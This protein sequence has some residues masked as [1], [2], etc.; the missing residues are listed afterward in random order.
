MP[1]AAMPPWSGSASTVSSKKP[2]STAPTRSTSP[3]SSGLDEKTAIRYAHSARAL[4]EQPLET[5]PAT[6]PRTPGSTP[7]HQGTG[8]AG[9]R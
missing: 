8:P 6:S 4:L 9:S 3:R 1:A 2:S 5:D 7:Q